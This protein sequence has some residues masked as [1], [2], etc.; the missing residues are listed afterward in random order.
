[1]KQVIHDAFKQ[2]KDEEEDVRDEEAQ[3]YW[4]KASSKLILMAT[5][6]SLPL[7]QTREAY[8]PEGKKGPKL[9]QSTRT[10]WKRRMRGQSKIA[11]IST[12][13]QTNILRTSWREDTQMRGEN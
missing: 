11:R 9:L 1:M 6:T 2:D 10:K 13:I 3:R 7:P 4:T 12:Q 5:K 8:T